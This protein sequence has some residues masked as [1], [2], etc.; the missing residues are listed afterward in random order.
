MIAD[1]HIHLDE[2]RYVNDLNTAW[3]RG[4]K[5]IGI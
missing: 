1:T 2:P 4:V 3:A 5:Y